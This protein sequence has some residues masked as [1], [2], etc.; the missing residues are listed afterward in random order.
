MVKTFKIDRNS[1][2]FIAGKT[3]TG[4]TYLAENLLQNVKR[5]IVLDTKS[6]LLKRFNLVPES[7]K[8]WKKFSG[9]EPIR[10][11]IKT[12]LIPSDQWEGYFDN[13]FKLAYDAGD[14]TVYLDEVYGVTQGS[15]N[16]ST[17]LTALY[18][19]GRELG[20]GVIACSQRPKHIP[21]FCMSES[22]H[23][24]VFRLLLQEDRDRLSSFIGDLPQ[25][26]NTDKHGFFYF[27]LDMNEPIYQK[28][29]G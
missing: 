20:I 5:L 21:M 13:I 18:T 12:P 4:K 26:P 15:R 16:L 6:N 2:V 10:M 24:F 25:I 28:S 1:R 23:F 17:W 22:E 27:N 8:N 7:K 11:Q 9:G 29:L 3:G 14:C 19:R